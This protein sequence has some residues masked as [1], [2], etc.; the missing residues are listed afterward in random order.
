MQAIQH[1]KEKGK[2]KDYDCIIG[3]SGGV[4]ET[5]AGVSSKTVR[6]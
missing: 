3:V 4:D 2:N 1:I 6:I 5:A